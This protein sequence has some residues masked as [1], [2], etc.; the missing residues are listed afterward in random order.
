MRVTF[1]IKAPDAQKVEFQL[2]KRYPA[3]KGD[4]GFWTVTT[5]P[6][7]AG[8]HYYFLVID[9]V[10]VTD[11]ASET[12]FG[13]GKE[14]SGIEVPEKGVDYYLPK[15]VP[16]GEVRVRWYF[17]K[18]TEA[19]RRAFVYVP[20]GYDTDRQTRYPVLYLQHGAGEDERGWSN[21][22]HLSFIMDNLLAEQKAK[23]MLVV[24]EQGYAQRPGQPAAAPAP[25]ARP[26]AP[27]QNAPP[28]RTSAGCSARSRM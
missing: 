11:P 14:T 20:P 21:Q 17:S 15:D 12:F 5:D 16:H 27:G 26:A 22:G 4:D 23:P 8:F 25:P 13:Y 24:M 28:R 7:V 2:G 18:T 6:Q 19:W 1:R 3:Q 9:G 10:Q